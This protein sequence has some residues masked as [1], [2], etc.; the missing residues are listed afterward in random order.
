MLIGR[1]RGLATPFAL[2]TKLEK[3]PSKSF[4]DGL[5]SMLG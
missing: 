2:A 4:S 1:P 5:Y 3:E